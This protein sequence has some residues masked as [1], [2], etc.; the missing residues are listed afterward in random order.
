MRQARQDDTSAIKVGIITLIGH[1]NLKKKHNPY[2][3]DKPE[4]DEL[5]TGG[6]KPRGYKNITTG[7]L[8]CPLDL[9]YEKCV[10]SLLLQ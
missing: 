2:L 3:V 6:V 1:F 10:S 7:A 8:L 5:D 9:E 4:V